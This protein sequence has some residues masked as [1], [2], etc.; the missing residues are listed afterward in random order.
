MARQQLLTLSDGKRLCWAEYGDPAGWPV[1]VFHGNPGSRLAWGAMPGTP[2]LDGIWL[3]APDRPAW[4]AEKMRNLEL[5]DEDKVVFDRPEIRNLFRVD[6][7]EAYRQQGLGSA[8]DATIP[9]RW[10]IPLAEIRMRIHLWHAERDQLVG[11]M[12]PYLAKHLSQAELRRLPGEGHLWILDH[13]PEV[14]ET[15]F[16]ANPSA[17]DTRSV[18]DKAGARSPSGLPPPPP[19]RPRSSRQRLASDSSITPSPPLH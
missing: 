19:P 10:P 9:S 11:N 18:Q 2:F 5:A 17:R 8:Y 7:P 15:L 6:F 1:F 16:N 14:L 3:V 4:V 12:T 13:M